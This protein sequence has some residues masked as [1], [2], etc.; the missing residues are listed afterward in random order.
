[1]ERFFQQAL[2]KLRID[3]ADVLLLGW[4]NQ[5]PAQRIMDRALRMQAKGMFRFLALSGHNRRLFPELSDQGLFDIFHL[6]YNAVHSGAEDEVFDKL[7][8]GGRPGIVTYTAT[9]WGDLLN[10]RRMPPNTM[11]LTGTDCYRFVLTRPDVDV[12]MTGPRTL[13]EMREALKALA[14]GSLSAQELERIRT[15]GDYI[16]AKHRRLF[17]S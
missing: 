1:M 2:K 12:C 6:R 8:G 10:P 7:G 16:H 9:R 3:T 5:Q 13:A 11:P 14:L 17:S 4:H 15:I